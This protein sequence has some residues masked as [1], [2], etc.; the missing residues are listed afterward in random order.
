MRDGPAAMRQSRLAALLKSSTMISMPAFPD[1]KA[2][3]QQELKDRLKQLIDK[4][5][6]VALERHA[7]H[8]QIDALR[9][10]LVARLRAR[11]TTS[12]PA[13]TSQTSERPASASRGARDPIVVRM[14]SR[15]LSHRR[16]TAE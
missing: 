14:G 12:S 8:V 4:E 16:P 10:E 3:G 9:S 13:V 6:K 5:Q 1:P 15:C 2:L 11:G 7:F